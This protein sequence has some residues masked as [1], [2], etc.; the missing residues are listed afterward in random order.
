M[1]RRSQRHKKPQK[2]HGY[3]TRIKNKFLNTAAFISLPVL[4]LG[5]TVILLPVSWLALPV[6]KLP[7]DTSIFDQHDKLI[8]VVYGSE[9]RMPITYK[10]V[11]PNIQNALV[12]IEDDTYWIEPAIDPVGILRAAVIDITSGQ[13]IQG[14]STLT[15]QLAKNLYLTDRRTFSRKF[16]ELLITLKL[17]TMFTKQQILAM[18]LNDVYFGQGCYGI[19]AASLR[20]F[21]HGI[22]HLTLPEAA[23]L[24]GVVN[25][26]TYYDPLVH[27][28]AAVA[29][30]NVV[31]SQ[32]AK[33]HYISAA[34]AK[35]AQ[36]APLHL[37]NGL[38]TANRAP[39]FTKYVLDQLTALA[40]GLKNVAGGGY[41]ITTTLSLKKQRAATNAVK[42]YL[43]R[44]HS[45]G[46]TLEPQVGL[47]SLNPSNG[48]IEA[49]V[50]G[51]NF[52]N[53]QFDRATRAFR[54]PGSAMKYFL[55]TTVI[56]NGYSTSSVQ[57]SAPVKFPAGGGKWY[58]P[59]NYG[60]V[61]NGWLPISYAIAYSDNIIATKWM[62]I[63]GPPAMIRMAHSMGITSPLANNLTT[64]LGSSSVSPFEMARGVSTLANGG[65]HV[66]PIAIL[67][68]LNSKGH[69]VYHQSPHKTRVITPQ[70]SYVVDKL[71]EGPLRIP[72]GTAYN[73]NPVLKGRPA[74]AK[75][76]TSSGQRDAWLVGFTPQL[77]TAV[78][79]GN[80]NDS[81]IYL[82]GDRGA[83]PIWAHFMKN[84]LAGQPYLH[85]HRP[86][87]IVNATVCRRT[88][89][90]TRVPGC[91]RSFREVFIK[92]HAPT[93]YSPGCRH[94]T[95]AKKSPKV[96]TKTHTRSGK[97]SHKK[98]KSI[99]KSILKGLL[100]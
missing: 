29:R 65:Y 70:V 95:V 36:A 93:K 24:A 97:S 44:A 10:Q 82:T 35:T 74:A 94:K 3:W 60:H 21:G 17:S 57:D 61:Y 87:G 11:P 41:Q 51:R 63:V 1:Q 84:A 73:L 88:G 64:A 15:Q 26:P 34:Q 33:L 56:N 86:P 46:G 92:G 40:P 22:K 47:V 27:P 28:H 83:G 49:F 45:V 85:F 91:C 31:L 58:V 16:K 96:K 55:Y 43:P 38:P 8:S 66:T 7:A 78:W 50:G 48:Y 75:T 62:N 77:A 52:A 90:L 6:P 79:V 32:M 89:L 19:Q 14:G 53:S 18:Y 54:Q 59:H 13:I 9:N 81:P 2:F 72:G 71:F 30:R 98:S 67:K 100:P 20:Y 42:A 68:V 69:E 25:A 37:S 23:T 99:L 5:A 80:D 12:A 76:G 39:Y 4:V